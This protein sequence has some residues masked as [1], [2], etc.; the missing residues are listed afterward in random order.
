MWEDS[1]QG[2]EEDIAH[3]IE[4]VTKGTQSTRRRAKRGDG[5]TMESAYVADHHEP[6]DDGNFSDGATRHAVVTPRKKQKTTRI[7]T[8]SSRRYV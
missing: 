5:S 2:K 8:P 7:I 6:D 1:Y 4:F 3:L